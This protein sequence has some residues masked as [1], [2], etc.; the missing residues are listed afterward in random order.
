MP[1]AISASIVTYRSSRA[2]S[3]H[4]S[5]SAP[6][7]QPKPSLRP[8]PSPNP[9]RLPAPS[10]E[11][12]L[13]SIPTPKSLVAHLD[14]YVIGQDV[15]KRRL[16]LAVSNHFKRLVDTWDREDPDPIIADADLRNVIVEKSNILL[17]GPKRSAEDP[18][19]S[20][21]WLPS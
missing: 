12:R 16:A 6:F 15:A 18:S 7:A 13:A 19:G 9:H 14:Q 1:A 3:I 17:I 11:A 8:S 5:A 4:P 20:K 10:K 2:A 21:P